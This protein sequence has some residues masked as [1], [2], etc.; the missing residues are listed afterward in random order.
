[1]ANFENYKGVCPNCGEEINAVVVERTRHI[2][3]IKGPDIPYTKL[4]YACGKCGKLF[5]TPELGDENVRRASEAL[6]EWKKENKHETLE[7]D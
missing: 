5:T 6:Q 2:K 4:S 7:S 3:P 1:M